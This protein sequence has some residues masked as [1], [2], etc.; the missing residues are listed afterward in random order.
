MEKIP[1]EEQHNYYCSDEIE[2][3]E[4]TTYSFKADAQNR[5]HTQRIL[6]LNDQLC[7][8][9]LTMLSWGD[10]EEVCAQI[11]FRSNGAVPRTIDLRFRQNISEGIG[12]YLWPSSVVL[13]RCE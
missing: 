9:E 8:R 7:S 2:L 1:L 10:V 6:R 11:E 3:L 4:V 12:N 13:T 5:V